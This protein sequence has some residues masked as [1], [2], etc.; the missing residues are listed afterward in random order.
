MLLGITPLVRMNIQVSPVRKDFASRQG[1]H[2]RKCPGARATDLATG[3]DGLVSL[4]LSASDTTRV[5]ITGSVTALHELI[6]EGDRQLTDLRRE[7][8]R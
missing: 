8:D 2:K 5:A 3:D 7:M 6:I 4:T 1:R